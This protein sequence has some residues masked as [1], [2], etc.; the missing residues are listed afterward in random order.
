MLRAI[1]NFPFTLT[2][3]IERAF[4]RLAGED[5]YRAGFHVATA[6]FGAL[7]LYFDSQKL[8]PGYAVVAWLS[9]IIGLAW[10]C[11]GGWWAFA[12]VPLLRQG[13]RLHTPP[14]IAPEPDYAGKPFWFRLE[15]LDYVSLGWIGLIAGVL[16]IGLPHA[17]FNTP[18]AYY[19]IRAAQEILETGKI[20]GHDYWSFA[21]L[22]RP[23][24]YPPL[25]SWLLA[26][27]AR[28]FDGDVFQAMRLMKVLWPL[29]V[30]STSWYVARWLFD[31]RWGLLA[32]LITGFTFDLMGVAFGAIPAVMAVNCSLL[33]LVCFLKRNFIAAI[34]FAVAGWYF[35]LSII[36]IS[37]AGLALFSLWNRSYFGGW[38]IVVAGACAGFAP[39]IARLAANSEWLREVKIVP[40]PG[41]YYS[42]YL[43]RVGRIFWLLYLNL[44]LA[45]LALRGIPMLR[46]AELRNCIILTQSVAF[47][48]MLF[49]YGGRFFMHTSQLW[50]LVI[51]APL[52][53]HLDPPLSNR[54]IALFLLVA[55]VPSLMFTGPPIAPGPSDRLLNALGFVPVV[56]GW[57]LPFMLAVDLR[58]RVGVIPDHDR[59]EAAAVFVRQ[60][61]DPSQIIYA[62]RDHM[63]GLQVATLAGRRYHSAA[64][65]EV[66]GDEAFEQ[67]LQEFQLQDTRGVYVT[68][69]NPD[70]LDTPHPLEWTEV[71]GI[72]LG[73]PADTASS[74]ENTNRRGP[75]GVN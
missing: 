61:S 30:Y 42:P 16:A 57:S 54:R 33:M 25:F 34:V 38:L 9:G 7:A 6:G 15:R 52:A 12:L 60:H 58:E 56:S 27:A 43:T 29:S 26:Q 65:L 3:L 75:S 67:Q 1:L 45:L 55:F 10:F 2:N 39:W 35:H 72:Y 74:A 64:W 44:F 32:L 51:A 23:H 59:A 69:S 48:P 5:W 31:A 62:P 13:H 70:S 49:S 4:K 21:P 24:L 18:D 46:W 47:V 50:A 8:G 53:R 14:S 36:P 20:P 28:L 66:R 19:H 63:L 41:L 71:S 68:R 40:T 11:L 37:L 73:L 22:G 17:S